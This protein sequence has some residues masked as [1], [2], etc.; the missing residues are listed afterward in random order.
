MYA[1][2]CNDLKN[3]KLAWKT[4]SNYFFNLLKGKIYF[5]AFKLPLPDNTERIYRT[6]LIR[7]L[8][9]RTL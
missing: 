4:I 7:N 5:S 9:N 6:F 1:E 8:F 2:D 3:L